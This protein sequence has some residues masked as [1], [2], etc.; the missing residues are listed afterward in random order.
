M[1]RYRH[2]FWAGAVLVGMATTAA[3]QDPFA[4]AEKSEAKPTPDASA[5]SSEKA[6]DKTAA[7]KAEPVFVRKSLREWQQVLPRNVFAV[8][9]LKATEPPFSGQ[10]AVGHFEGTFICVCCEAELFSSKAKFDS[11]TGWPSFWQPVNQKA[12]SRAI[13]NSE[14]E[15]RVE[16]MCS[17]CG[18]HLGHVFD[19]GY[20]TPTGLRFC[21]NSLSLKLE[22][23]KG[24]AARPSTTRAR[25]RVRTARSRSR[26]A[27]H[28]APSGE[29]TKSD[30][31]KPAAGK[32]GGGE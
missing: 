20:G 25:S 31:E 22:P 13:D 18:A 9:R 21:I 27:T 30:D 5:K 29:S 24:Q 15:P 32:P 23:G 26:T 14:G 12:I 17:R 2:V 1:P 8:T 19:D 10:Y 4:A 7:K 11:G 6:A 28:P 3:A 16:V